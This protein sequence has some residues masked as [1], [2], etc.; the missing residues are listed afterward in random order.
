MAIYH[1]NDTLKLVYTY[2]H[3]EKIKPNSVFIVEQVYIN[4][5]S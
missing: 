3:D 2:L 4:I 5:Y 1:N